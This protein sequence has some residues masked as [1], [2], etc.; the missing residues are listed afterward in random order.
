[1]DM[2]T[3]WLGNGTE[4]RRYFTELPSTNDY[5]KAHMAELA[6]GTVVLAKKQTAGKGRIGRKWEADKGDCLCF[7]FALRDVPIHHLPLLPLICGMA[8]VDAL[9]QLIP[10]KTG[11]KWP[12]DLVIEGKKVCG[13]LCES[14]FSGTQADAVCGIG[15]NLRQTQAQFTAAG[16]PHAGS[17]FSLT[18]RCVSPQT[19]LQKI[20]Q[21][22]EP[23]YTQLCQEGF[24]SLRPQYEAR[25]LTVGKEIRVMQNGRE[26]SGTALG[27][28]ENGNLLCNLG[29]EIVAISSGEASVRGLYGYV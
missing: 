1:M 9:D 22:F 18:G 11:I 7:S 16:L 6:H 4:K 3:Q 19:L 28:A 5:I 27:I 17:L 13:I 2:E 25:C 14:L 23:L 20:L 15:I 12:N 21:A 10:G 26:S 8:G 29:G 24:A